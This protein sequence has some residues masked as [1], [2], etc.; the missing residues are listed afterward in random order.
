MNASPVKALSLA[1][2]GVL[3]MEGCSTLPDMR[4]AKQSKVN[5]DYALAIKNYK[6]LADS[7][8]FDAAIYLGDTYLQQN[9]ANAE[10]LAEASYRKTAVDGTNAK[11]RG[12][13]EVRLAKLLARKQNATVAELKESDEIYRKLYQQGNDEVLPLMVKLHMAHPQL[14]PDEDTLGIVNEAKLRGLPDANLALLLLYKRQGYEQA[15]LSEMA[16]LCEEVLSQVVGCYPE[17]AEI[18]QVSND[19]ESLSILFNKA[20]SAEAFRALD[21]LSYGK[22]AR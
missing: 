1:L 4:L 7:G 8:Y 9:H 22:C 19:S 18:Y 16:L 12:Y 3:T 6:A 5:G 20:K 2:A 14:W 15:N 17:L 21:S 11:T 10:R 13:A